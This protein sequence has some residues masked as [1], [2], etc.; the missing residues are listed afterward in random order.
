MYRRKIKK[1]CSSAIVTA[2][3]TPLLV[4]MIEE[5]SINEEISHKIISNYL[6]NRLLEG[7]DSLI[8]A[9][10]HYPLI[11]NEI[12]AFYSGKVQLID[13]VTIVANSIKVE[14]K[15]MQLINPNNN[16]NYQFYISNYTKS[17]AKSAKFFFQEEIKI[18]EVNIWN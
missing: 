16:P 2:L 3:A 11:F 15:S 6:S 17:F 14:L 10:T 9:C 8:L 4:P 13:S 18:K 7:I 1:K 5:G 12:N